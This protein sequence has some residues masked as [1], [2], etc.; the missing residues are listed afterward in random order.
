MAVI[1][2][3]KELDVISARNLQIGYQKPLGDHLHLELSAG[4]F[5]MILGP[6]GSGKSTLFKTLIG[7]I[8]PMS[9]QVLVNQLDVHRLAA[10]ARAK[11]FAY[12]P[13]SQQQVF[14]YTVGEMV[15][16]GRTS[17]I[18]PFSV[19]S[20]SD[21]ELCDQAMASLDIL[22]LKNQEFTKLSGGQRQLTILARALAQDAQILVLDEPTASLDFGNEIRVLERI[23][24]LADQGWTIILSTHN[25]DHAL[26][27]ADTVTTVSH[28]TVKDH[29]VPHQILTSAH[30]SDLYQANVEVVSI[31]QTKTCIAAQLN[32]A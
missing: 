5:H 25:P 22:G 19:P 17:H 10:T 18:K 21:I 24:H 16:M 13:Q 9:G 4:Q 3:T 6:N 23:R 15:L 28:G 2:R 29:G 31:G 27:L 26:Q 7:L 20:H 12:V 8:R 1:P 30:L 32:R 11:T 14:P